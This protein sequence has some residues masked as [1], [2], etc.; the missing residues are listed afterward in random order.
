[1]GKNSDKQ[2][3][4]QYHPDTPGAAKIKEGM[5]MD[6]IRAAI[7]FAEKERLQ[8]LL[9]QELMQDVFIEPDDEE[10]KILKNLI[11]KMDVPQQNLLFFVY[12]YG[13]SFTEV[14]N[15]L[16]VEQAEARLRLISSYLAELL[17]YE[18]KFIAKSTLEEL[19]IEAMKELDAQDASHAKVIEQAQSKPFTAKRKYFQIFSSKV[20]SGLVAC[21]ILA[22]LL[23]GANVLADGKIFAFITEKFETYTSFI[24]QSEAPVER[25]PDVS[26][27]LG[28]VPDGF[29]LV[30]TEE[31]LDV[32]INEYRNSEDDKLVFV[33][34][35]GSADFLLDT[36]DT[37]V[38][39]IDRHNE[40][41]YL[42]ER[43]GLMYLVSSKEGL[44]YQIYGNVSREEI[45]NMHEQIKI[46]H[47]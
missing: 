17:G 32:Q 40:K 37:Q 21:L 47:D 14:E 30:K 9:A 23:I 44:A 4:S 38:E 28:Y 39:E 29:T 2:N 11:L 8:N 12:G 6:K 27:E 41:I 22:I 20:T 15:I 16:A 26:L 24:F 3:C 31:L 42:W 7:K 36:E 1:M 5:P 33:I 35:K 45:L 43:R 19:S 25:L 18:G 13:H 34:S 46:I 10:R